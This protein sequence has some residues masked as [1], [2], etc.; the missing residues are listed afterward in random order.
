MT[1]AGAAGHSLGARDK[2][3]EFN[4]QTSGTHRVGSQPND[5]SAPPQRRFRIILPKHLYFFEQHFQQVLK[6][7]H[8]LF[9]SSSSTATRLQSLE[10]RSKTGRKTFKLTPGS[11]VEIRLTEKRDR[12]HLLRKGSLRQLQLCSRSSRVGAWRW[13]GLRWTGETHFSSLP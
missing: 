3:R 11:T 5:L 9:F 10:G 8:I 13:A 2:A 6:E 4:L 7:E 1:L 12:R